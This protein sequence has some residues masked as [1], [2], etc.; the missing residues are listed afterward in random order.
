MNVNDNADENSLNVCVRA[1]LL[2][3]FSNVIV[4]YSERKRTVLGHPLKRLS[5]GAGADC[6]NQV[7][8]L[9]LSRC[10]ELYA[11]DPHLTLAIA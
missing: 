11:V 2:A 3:T 6:R 9:E 10:M 1:L 5:I 4:S 7:K 8:G